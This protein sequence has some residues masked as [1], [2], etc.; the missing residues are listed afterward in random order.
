ML[1]TGIIFVIASIA[2]INAT[3]YHFQLYGNELKQD[4]NNTDLLNIHLEQAIIQSIGWTIGGAMLIAFI[5]S[6]YIARRISSPMIQMKKLTLLMASG[7]R[8]VRLPLLGL[9]KDEV[10]QLAASINHLA[11]QLQEQEQLKVT[12]T[13]NIAHELRTPLTTINSYLFAIQDG[14]WEATPQRMKSIR[15]E[16]DRLIQL[17]SDLE[18]LNSLTSP[19]FH[20]SLKDIRISKTIDQVFDLI[21][22]SYSERGIILKKGKIPDVIV[23]ADENRLIQIWNNLLSNALKFTPTGG[24]V[25]IEGKESE[26]GVEII[27]QDTGIGIPNEELPHVF[28]RFY[29]VDKSRNRKTG[30]GGLGLAITKTLVERHEGRIWAESDGGTSFHIYLMRSSHNDGAI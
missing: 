10:D 29:R 24:K 1:Y 28:E 23:H 13:E 4:P 14:I 9:P 7:K 18:E 19:E 3:H 25:W 12:M 2:I 22:P 21:Q 8:D 30:G 20:L 17:V 5:L 11:E 26:N 6:I 15:E 16:I 27:V